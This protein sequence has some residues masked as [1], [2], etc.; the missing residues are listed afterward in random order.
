V[1][2]IV[3]YPL[4]PTALAGWQRYAL[5]DRGHYEYID[6][7]AGIDALLSTVTELASAQLGFGLTLLTWRAVRL[8]PGDYLLSHHDPRHDDPLVEC[9]A[10][11]ST[12]PSDFAVHYRENGRPHFVVPNTPGTV[13]VVARTAASAANHSYVSKLHRGE[14][15]TR[16]VLRLR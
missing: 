3:T 7:P 1:R 2:T 9:I 6:R 11:L 5:V 16:V 13:S 10:D 4:P 15:L 8:S 12:A 14:A